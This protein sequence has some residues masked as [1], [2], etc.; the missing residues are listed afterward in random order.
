MNHLEAL[1][2]CLAFYNIPVKKVE[3]NKVFTIKEYLI[4]VEANG[5]YRLL[6]NEEVIAPFDDLNEVCTFIVQY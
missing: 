6:Q 1:L 3:A 4:E 2:D 5:L